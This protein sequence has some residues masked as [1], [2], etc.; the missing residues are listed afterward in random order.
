MRVLKSKRSRCN[1]RV[2]LGLLNRTD[3]RI[4]CRPYQEKLCSWLIF[5]AWLSPAKEAL[6]RVLMVSELESLGLSRV[7]SI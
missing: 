4:H 5:A 2:Y 3:K 1:K 6:L 7:K